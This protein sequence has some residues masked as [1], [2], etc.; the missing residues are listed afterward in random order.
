MTR[1]RR[2]CWPL[3]PELGVAAGPKLHD[4]T[5]FYGFGGG[6]DFNATKHLHFRCD[7]EFVHVFLFSD[8]LAQLAQQPARLDWPDL[9][10]WQ[11]RKQVT[12]RP[13]S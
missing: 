8:L 4:T 2:S 3:L 13:E 5:Y 1:S 6:A 9:Q 11:Q 10:L 7:V 12:A